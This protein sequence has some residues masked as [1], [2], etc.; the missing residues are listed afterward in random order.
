MDMFLSKPSLLVPLHYVICKVSNLQTTLAGWLFLEHTCHDDSLHQESE[1]PLIHGWIR[2]IFH[3]SCQDLEWILPYLQLL[4]L[5]SLLHVSPMVTFI[6]DLT[7]RVL[8][9]KQP[10][11]LQACIVHF[12]MCFVFSFVNFEA[13]FWYCFDTFWGKYPSFPANHTHPHTSPNTPDIFWDWR[14]CPAKVYWGAAAKE[15]KK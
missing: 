2:I 15:E 4:A 11:E 5:V 14:N 6:R 12:G 1:Y 10:C 8:A 7:N 13:M 9:R 3:Q